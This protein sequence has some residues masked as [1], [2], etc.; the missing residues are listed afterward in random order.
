MSPFVIRCPGESASRGVGSVE[1]PDA[2]GAVDRLE[3]AADAGAFLQ[4]AVDVA[5]DV[6]DLGVGAQVLA[7]DVKRRPR[8]PR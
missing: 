8:T 5:D 3:I 7:G 6:A 2:D 1:K 4:L